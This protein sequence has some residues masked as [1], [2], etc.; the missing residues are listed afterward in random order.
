MNVIEAAHRMFWA[1][2]GRIGRWDDIPVG[3][4]VK[5]IDD[6]ERAAAAL[7]VALEWPEDLR[8]AYERWKDE[9]FLAYQAN[10]GGPSVGEVEK[11]FEEAV[12]GLSTP[13]EALARPNFDYI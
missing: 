5:M 1:S 13:A 7:N 4:R 11:R 10:S 3:F 12:S 6:T 2:G 8:T 9:L